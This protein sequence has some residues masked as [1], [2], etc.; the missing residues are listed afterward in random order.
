MG[1]HKRYL[2]MLNNVL[3]ELCEKTSVSRKLC[4]LN[5]SFEGHLIRR[6]RSDEW[7]VRATDEVRRRRSEDVN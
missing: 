1:W 4:H 5:D 2:V 6:A 7:R 3:E